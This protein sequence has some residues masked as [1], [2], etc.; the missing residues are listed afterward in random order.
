MKKGVEYET[1]EEKYLAVQTNLIKVTKC[2][3]WKHEELI[4]SHTL[5]SYCRIKNGNTL[6]GILVIA[7]AVN[8]N[9]LS[10]ILAH[11]WFYSSIKYSLRAFRIN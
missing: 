5:A 7:A 6:T 8:S 2:C 1:V 9:C 11:A 4:P 3:C 10:A